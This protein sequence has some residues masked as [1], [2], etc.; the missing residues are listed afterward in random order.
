MTNKSYEVSISVLMPIYNGA[1][2]IAASIG[3]VMAQ[4]FTN[5]ELI[6]L[7]DGSNDNS[8]EILKQL[9]QEDNRIHLYT[10]TNNPN[11]KVARNISIMCQCAKGQCAFYMSQNDTLSPDCL[12]RLYTRAT[13]ID[14]NIVCA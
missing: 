10:K 8:Y 6:A 14:A 3:S 5:W 11:G 4:S 9:S 12:E 1:E 2:Y 13:E 7:D